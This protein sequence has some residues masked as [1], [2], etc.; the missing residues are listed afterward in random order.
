MK[1]IFAAL[2]SLLFAFSVCA[3]DS[4]FYFTTSDSTQLF[5]RIAGQ[6]KPCLFVHGGPG[7]TSY[8]YEA[9]GSAQIIERKMKMIY[10]DQRG[11]GR[12]GS[13][14][15]GDYSLARMVKDMEELRSLL[16]YNKWAVM[17]HSF[18]GILITAYAHQQPQSVSALL[19]I[20]GTLNIAYSM[21][22]HLEYGLK[23]LDIKDQAE[24]RDT[25][26]PLQERVGRI[27]NLLTE[28]NLWYGLMFRNAYEK[29]YSDSLTFSVKNFNWEFG[30]RVWGIQDYWKDFTPLTAQIKCPVFV[31]TGDNDFAIGPSH[32]QSF[33]F[34][35]QQVVRY[36]GGHVP[37][38]EEP[39]WF[40][41][42]VLGFMATL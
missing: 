7:S 22:S 1:P 37:F 16:G 26:K 33:R 14:R 11:S 38:Q 9:N 10:F 24:Y 21:T 41:E 34:P 32:Y 31:M 35:H 3:R 4:T 20:H 42:K 17:G 23:A 19:L 27:H 39:Q 13:A 2:F 6:G 40:A 18:G 8:Y 12:S 29:K 36:I 28:H 25:T 30:G 5:V 15:N